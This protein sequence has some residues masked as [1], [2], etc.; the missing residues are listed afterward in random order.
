[1]IELY[2]LFLLTLLLKNDNTCLTTNRIPAKTIGIKL[3]DVQ[4]D[5]LCDKQTNERLRMRGRGI[6]TRA[7]NRVC[8]MKNKI[9]EKGRNEDDK[10][11]KLKKL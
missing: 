5:V 9:I 7:R 1:M 3:L 10:K 4:V 6:V 8:R 2:R 11:S